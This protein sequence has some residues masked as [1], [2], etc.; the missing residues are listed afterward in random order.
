[1]KRVLLF[2]LS[3]VVLAVSGCGRTQTTASWA[4]NSINWHHRKG[5]IS[6]CF[7]RRQ[8]GNIGN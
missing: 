5:D 1:M 7:K 2:G 8:P 4:F 3:L 6:G